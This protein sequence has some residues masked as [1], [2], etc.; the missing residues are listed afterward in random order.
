MA[1]EVRYS[2]VQVSTMLEKN[3][4]HT[5]M[6]GSHQKAKMTTSAPKP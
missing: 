3:R 5:R 1:Q 6:S 2:R 4:F